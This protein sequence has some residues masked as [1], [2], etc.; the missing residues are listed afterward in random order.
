M[1]VEFYT[2]PETELPHIYRHDVAEYEVEDV[3]GDRGE[4]NPTRNN[5]R[6]AIGQTRG[7]RY[8][9]VVYRRDSETGRLT[10]ITAY[11]LRGSALTA[12][13]RRQRR[14]GRR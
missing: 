14:R 3:L 6:L 5:S 8:L 4:D 7:G 9:M 11:E 1:N 13:R 10:V 2:D 12:Y